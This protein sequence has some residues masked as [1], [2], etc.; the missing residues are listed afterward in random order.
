MDIVNGDLSHF[1]RETS[2]SQLKRNILRTAKGVVSVESLQ[3]MALG[4]LGTISESE[5]PICF[6]NNS[7]ATEA[8]TGNGDINDRIS[9]EL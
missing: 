3:Y 9:L 4:T 2:T 1:V 6:S 5:N 8:D 7:E